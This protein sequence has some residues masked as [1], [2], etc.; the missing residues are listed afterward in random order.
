MRRVHFVEYH[1]PEYATR[2]LTNVHVVLIPGYGDPDYRRSNQTL[3]AWVHHWQRVAGSAFYAKK[4]LDRGF[5]NMQFEDD[6]KFQL[7]FYD[8]THGIENN[9]LRQIEKNTHGN[10]WNFYTALGWDYKRKKFLTA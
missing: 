10:I 6:W 9:P 7:E 1:E 5:W 3:G 8:S 4:R 2:V